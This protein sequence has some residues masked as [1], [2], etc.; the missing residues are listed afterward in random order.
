MNAL[1]I[2]IPT[3]NEEIHIERALKSALSLTSNIF[4]VDSHSTDKTVEIAER[5]GVKVFQYKWEANSNWAK[6]FN[7]TLQHVPFPTSWIMRLDADEYLTLDFIQKIRLELYGLP[8][9]VT[10]ISINRRE[11]FMRRWMKHGGTYPK[12]MIRIV[13]KGKAFFESRII[14]EHIEITEGRSI[15]WN[16]DICDDKIISLTKWIANHNIHATKEAITLIDHELGLF[17]TNDETNNLDA[18][19]FK[20]RK[21][22]NFYAKLPYFW[23]AWAFFAYR[24]VIKFGF[25]DGVEGFLYCF[26][27]C[28][29]YRTIAD[30]KILEAYRVCGKNKDALIEY[31]YTEYNIDCRNSTQQSEILSHVSLNQ[32]T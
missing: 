14:D 19:A 2:F 28:L 24:Y 15:Y 26:L 12:T 4:V 9:D 8:E 7:W 30:A 10:A 1:S 23:R 17:S 21:K 13:R 31:F 29:W 5:M 20:T 32:S 6:K 25:K 3:F 22:K 11:Y 18:A 27:Q 16:I